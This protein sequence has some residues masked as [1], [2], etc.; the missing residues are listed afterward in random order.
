MA[1]AHTDVLGGGSDRTVNLG[2]ATATVSVLFT[3][4]VDSTVILNHDGAAL[5]HAIRRCRGEEIK[6]TGDGLM[7]VF[8]SALDAVECAVAMQRAVAR[9]RREEPF[10]PEVRVGVSAGEATVDNDDWYGQPV[11]EASRLCSTAERGQILLTD[12]VA[13]LIRTWTKYRIVSVGT[14]SLKGFDEPVVVREVEW[15]DGDVVALPLPPA[16]PPV[17]REVL[18]DREAEAERL[19]MAWERAKAGERTRESVPPSRPG[20]QTPADEAA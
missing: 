4:L 9:L 18:V 11:V 16:V 20:E 3:D 2:A 14:R 1:L 19:V 13:A 8:R 5:R 12:V 15:A 6:T 7:V 17:A 10:T